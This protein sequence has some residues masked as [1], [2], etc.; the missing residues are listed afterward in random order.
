MT[1]L[2]FFF[3]YAALNFCF[4]F[5]LLLLLFFLFFFHLPLP[6]PLPL[7][8][9][10]QPLSAFSTVSK[11]SFLQLSRNSC[12]SFRE[13]K[14]LPQISSPSQLIDFDFLSLFSFSWNSIIL[15]II[16]AWNC[17]LSRRNYGF[18]CIFKQKW[19]KSEEKS[20]ESVIKCFN[21]FLQIF[22]KCLVN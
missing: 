14:P 8:I 11:L 3:F 17:S 15:S 4:W 22:F 16:Y 10:H 2:L 20:I 12:S 18:R 5:S 21:F 7:A 13:C 9:S 19:S 6:L 1:F